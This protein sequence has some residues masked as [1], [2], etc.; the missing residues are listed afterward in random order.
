MLENLST[1]QCIILIYLI[2]KSLSSIF[3]LW[4]LRK[5]VLFQLKQGSSK[6]S[7]GSMY[8]W[9]MWW[10]FWCFL[11][12]SRKR[13]IVVPGGGFDAT[14]RYSG[15]GGEEKADPITSGGPVHPGL[16][17]VYTGWTTTLL[18]PITDPWGWYIYL[19]E[20]LKF[21]THV[22]KYTT[23]GSHGYRDLTNQ[24]NGK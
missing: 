12:G 8:I 16:F 7:K 6:I 10:D 2:C 13:Q 14:T 23:H 24:Y 4:P 21:M 11:C 9:Y 20:W 22:G 17:E 18:Y 1:K 19:H 5:Q 15:R 3:S